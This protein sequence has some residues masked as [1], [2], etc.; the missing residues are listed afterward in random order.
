MKGCCFSF[1][2]TNDN[3]W[4]TCIGNIYNFNVIGRGA[5][6]KHG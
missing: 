5:F 1:G 3:E 4:A 6:V 2:K